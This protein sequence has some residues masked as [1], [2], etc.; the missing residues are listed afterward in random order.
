[1]VGSSLS[2]LPMLTRHL[3]QLAPFTSCDLQVALGTTRLRHETDA[4][5]FRL[6]AEALWDAIA[7]PMRSCATKR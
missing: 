6:H 3:R 7:R 5:R 2:D 4:Q 1:M